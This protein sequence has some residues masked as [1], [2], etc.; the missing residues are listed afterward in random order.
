MSTRDAV[1]GSTGYSG[2]Y[3]TRRL[4]A[5]GHRILNLTGHPERPNDFGDAVTAAP[6]RFD[7][8]DELAR[9]LAAVDTLYCT[10]WVRFPLGDQT[11]A[12][13]VRNTKV[14]F[15]AAERA[16]VR[17]VVYV[18]I[19][20]PSRASRLTYFSGKAELED[21]LRSKSLSHAILRPAVLFGGGVGEDILINNIAWFLRR[22]PVFGIPGDGTYRLQPIHV[23]DQADLAVAQGARDESVTLD[24]TGPETFRFVDLVR[25]I[26][27]EIGSKALL[28]RMP[29]W[30]A[31]AATRAMGVI[32]RDV[33][34]TRDEVIGLMDDLL[35]TRSESSG[36][37]RL[38]AWLKESA[39][40]L[41]RTYANEIAR[42]TV[43]ARRGSSSASGRGRPAGTARR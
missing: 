40:T 15:D 42:R 32:V 22:L 4:L 29:P 18:S 34:L 5:R 23:E 16:G 2:K 21:H 7:E 3:I 33:I 11:H 26:K 27:Q 25:L 1:T 37:T 19:T 8:P 6:F 38:T 10:Y 35:V 13:A 28:V 43:S 31:H 20:N 30:M 14:L 9:S 12:R 17:R 36:S 24:A 41:G 39:P